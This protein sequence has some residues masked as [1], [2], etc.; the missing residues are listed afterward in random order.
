MAIIKL[1]SGIALQ[2]EQAVPRVVHVPSEC[3][4]R[5]AEAI[6]ALCRELAN[7]ARFAENQR[8]DNDKARADVAAETIVREFRE[9]AKAQLAGLIHCHTCMAQQLATMAAHLGLR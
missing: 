6:H 7:Q 1:P 5:E 8:R 9:D 3:D 2:V 4:A